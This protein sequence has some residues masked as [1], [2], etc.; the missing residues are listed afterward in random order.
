MSRTVSVALW[1]VVVGLVA[2][3]YLGGFAPEIHHWLTH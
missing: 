3:T 2:T 1:L